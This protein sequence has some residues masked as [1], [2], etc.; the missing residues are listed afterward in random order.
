MKKIKWFI[1]LVLLLFAVLYSVI[2]SYRVDVDI[3]DIDDTP[4]QENA[5]LLT[6]V[7]SFL[8]DLF[9]DSN[10]DEYTL[11]ED[12][13]N[14]VIVD[15]I[16]ENINEDYNP[17]DDC[18]SDDCKYIIYSDDYYVDYLWA[19]LNDDNQIV[20][21]IGLGTDYLDFHTVMRFYFDVSIDYT[22]LEI[23]LSLNRYEIDETEL[24]ISYLDTILEGSKQEIEDSIT[25]GELDLDE[26]TYTITFSIMDLF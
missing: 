15:S 12:I 9:V 20:V 21:N 17:F 11:V 2:S 18:N 14:Y 13:I 19:D 3:N 6:V 26:Y 25:F 24:K 7:H 1:I 10:T 16:H 8:V 4:Y 22:S 23:E 5:N